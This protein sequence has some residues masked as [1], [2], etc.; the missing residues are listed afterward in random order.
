GVRAHC[1]IRRG[2]GV[3]VRQT[4]GRD[5]PADPHRCRDAAAT[6]ALWREPATAGGVL[7][8]GG[9]LRV[10]RGAPTS[11]QGT[12]LQQSQRH[13]RRL[14]TGRRVRAPGGRDRQARQ[15]VRRRG[16]G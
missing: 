4:A 16:G 5:F 6:A 9:A 13:R 15:P 8:R 2:G 14:C 3:V 12:V 10:G 7:C 1:V 11:G